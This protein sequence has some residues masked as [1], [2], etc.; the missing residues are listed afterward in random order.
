M[1]TSAF[2]SPYSVDWQARVVGPPDAH[3]TTTFTYADPISV[4]VHGW[5]PPSPDQQP[6]Q[7]DRAPVVIALHLTADDFPGG[8]KDRVTVG[9]Q[10]FEQIGY[11][12]D[13]RN[14]PFGFTPG[15]RVSLRRVE[16]LG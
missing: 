12:E 2:P 4:P 6:D 14:G 3:G 9:G 7:S 13:F 5:A 15:V 1:T 10:M 8:P 11:P 16:E